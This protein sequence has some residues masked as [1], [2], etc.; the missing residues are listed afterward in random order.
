MNRPVRRTQVARKVSFSPV[1]VTRDLNTAPVTSVDRQ[2]PRARRVQMKL[3]LAID[4]I[5]FS[6]FLSKKKPGDGDR[7]HK[8]QV[9]LGGAEDPHR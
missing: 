9:G 2:L 1:L 5:F 4:R 8:G 3:I 7:D 6:C